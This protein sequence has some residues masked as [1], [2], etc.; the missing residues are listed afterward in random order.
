MSMSKQQERE[1]QERN[2]SMF[3]KLR[4]TLVCALVILTVSFGYYYLHDQRTSEILKV[5]APQFDSV[6][7]SDEKAPA[8]GVNT[9]HRT[10]AGPEGPTFKFFHVAKDE[11]V[12][13]GEVKLEGLVER[14]LA[15]REAF[16]SVL[17]A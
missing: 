12:L 4:L 9:W 11:T 14:S 16:D 5:L 3:V 13:E 7:V 8:V 1:S 15:S 6:K 17:L 10:Y 2:P